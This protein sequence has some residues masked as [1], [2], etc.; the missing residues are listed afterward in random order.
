MNPLELVNVRRP[1]DSF[2]SSSALAF[3]AEVRE[4]APIASS[5]A[6]RTERTR[7]RIEIQAGKYYQVIK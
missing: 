2:F 7:P 4:M 5:L 1:F 3:S 6:K